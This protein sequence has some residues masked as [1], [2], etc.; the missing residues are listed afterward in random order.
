MSGPNTAKSLASGTPFDGRDGLGTTTAAVA[1]D[2]G[3][4]KFTGG[5]AA[6]ETTHSANVIPAH[7]A[8]REVGLICTG[9]VC[10]F[11][12]S[13][14]STAEVDRAVSATAAGAA[15]KVGVPLP[16]SLSIETRARVPDAPAG[17]QVYFVRESD[18]TSTIVYMRLL[19]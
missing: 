17:Q 2:F 5:V 10:Y 11:A 3:V 15:G 18:A 14:N 1:N 8:G 19:A 6:T 16:N 4:L 12:F 9:G 7:W 13:L